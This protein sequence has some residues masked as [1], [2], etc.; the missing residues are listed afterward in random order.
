MAMFHSTDPKGSDRAY[1]RPCI[2]ETGYRYPILRFDNKTFTKE[3]YS[4]IESI[5]N[6]KCMT[7]GLI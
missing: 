6:R 1:S 3:I 5:P 4:F 2:S 7:T